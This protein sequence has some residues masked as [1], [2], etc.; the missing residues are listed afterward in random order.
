MKRIVGIIF[1]SLF[2]LVSANEEKSSYKQPVVVKAINAMAAT[3]G[4][5]VK[6]TWKKYTRGDLLFYKVVKSKTNK[7]PVYPEDGYIY[8]T[9]DENITSYYDKKIEEGTWY[10]R[11][12]IITKS[13]E[14]LV[15]EVIQVNIKKESIESKVPTEKDFE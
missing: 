11:V 15:S 8:Y 13:K 12:C 4:K 1:F 2:L 6:I 10:Y 5:T 9:T 14:R 7:N 3:E